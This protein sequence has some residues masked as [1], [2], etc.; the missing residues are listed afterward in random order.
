MGAPTRRPA[1]FALCLMLAVTASRDAAAQ[2]V[3]QRVDALFGQWNGSDAPGCALGVIRDGRLIH[4][5]GFGTA[6]L[7]YGIPNSP[8][9]VY[10]VGSVS[11]QFTAASIALL[12]LDGRISMDD[13]IRT[14]IPELP[15][16]GRTIT[17]DHLV[18]HTSGL[19]DIYVL[20]DLAG[21]RMED[22]FTD[23][24]AL[25]LIARQQEL[26]FDPGTDYL[27][28]NTGYW[29][30]GQIVERV[31]GESLRE[32]ARRNIFEPLGMTRSHFHDDPGH[33]MTDRV[34]SYI[35][36]PSGGY[37]IAFLQNFDKIGAGGLYTTV[38]DLAKWD[39]NFYEPRVGGQ[40][41]LDLVH[42]RGILD[43]GDTLDYAFG[44]TVGA[45]RGLRT[46]RHGG[47]LMGYRAELLRFP[48][49][50]F[51]VILLCNLGTL[52]PGPL[53]EDV[54][55]IYLDDVMAP[56]DTAGTPSRSPRIVGETAPPSPPANLATALAGDYASDELRAV[57][58]IENADSALI[59][60]RPLH[61]PARLTPV[62]PDTWRQGSLVLRFE[63][64]PTGFRYTAFTVQAGRVSNIRF[65]RSR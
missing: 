33:P 46:V 22:V 35:P 55:A 63:W 27:Y 40:A 64:D 43:S 6:N 9:M 2:S 1:A 42:T 11:K 23:E 25:A 19:R 13:D 44:L 16:Y 15:D 5:R 3:D 52:N 20:M 17:I 4:S 58:R 56:A 37:R 51:S 24:D 61:E 54:A 41:F 10:Y 59:L 45:Y 32:F 31:T 53:A 26:N 57:W 7:D 12:E 30:L 62:E 18:H 65:T 60:H 49:Q 28:S 36:D 50:R 29:L 48:D 47:S 8:T 39:A 34:V 14:Y 21:I 38:E